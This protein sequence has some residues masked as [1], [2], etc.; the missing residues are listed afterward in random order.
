LGNRQALAALQQ[1]V[2][3]WLPPAGWNAGRGYD[4]TRQYTELTMISQTG[5]ALVE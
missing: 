5:L 2:D 4:V 3:E 1:P